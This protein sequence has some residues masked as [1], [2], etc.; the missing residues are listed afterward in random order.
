MLMLKKMKT[1]LRHRNK[2]SNKKEVQNYDQ[3]RS[4][5]TAV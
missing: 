3:E 5:K 2:D 4:N 1:K